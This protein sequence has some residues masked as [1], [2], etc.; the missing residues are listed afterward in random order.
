MS[1]LG[2]PIAHGD[3]A[4]L[5]PELCTSHLSTQSP[6]P[7]TNDWVNCHEESCTFD[8]LAT[9]QNAVTAQPVLLLCVG[10]LTVMLA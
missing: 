6:P 8:V 7:G 5:Q 3:S 1:Q 10:Y 2:W 9:E 4:D